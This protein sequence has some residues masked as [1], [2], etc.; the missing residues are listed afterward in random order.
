MFDH[1]H[2][3]YRFWQID[4]HQCRSRVGGTRRGYIK[5]SLGHNFNFSHSLASSRHPRPEEEFS[6]R[7]EYIVLVDTPGFNDDTNRSDHGDPH[8]LMFWL[9]FATRRAAVGDHTM[10]QARMTG[11]GRRM[12]RKLCGDENLE[13]HS[14]TTVGAQAAR[15]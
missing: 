3:A 2:G 11:S 4:V 15:R 1:C 9:R 12:F 5:L 7:L 10:T 6:C 14:T 8:I 13:C